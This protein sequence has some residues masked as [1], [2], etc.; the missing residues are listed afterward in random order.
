MPGCVGGA[1]HLRHRTGGRDQPREGSGLRRQAR[2]RCAPTGP[3]RLLARTLCRFE[4]AGLHVVGPDQPVSPPGPD[5]VQVRA[6][7]PARSRPRPARVAFRSGLCA[8]YGRQT[9]TKSGPSGL[10]RLQ[11]RTLCRPEPAGLHEVGPDR[12][13][14]PPGPD[15]VQV[16]AGRQIGRASCRERV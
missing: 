4:P 11:V 13:A 9:C 10:C 2:T 3:C 14:L 7:R 8:G 6:A 1:R 12:P 5:F 15:F 16:R